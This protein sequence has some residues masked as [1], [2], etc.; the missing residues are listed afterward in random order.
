MNLK[1][2]GLGAL[3]VALVVAVASPPAGAAVA[4]PGPLDVTG[5]IAGAPFRIVVPAEWNG[6]LLV[7]AHGYVDKADHPGEVDER[8]TF[9]APG[10][11]TAATL[12]GQGWALAGT[13]YKDN[14]WAVQEALDDLVALTSYFK[15]NVGNPTRTLLVGG[16]MGSVPTLELAE[17][18]GGAFDG[19][20]AYCGLGGG[21]P[22]GADWLATLRLA[23]DVTFGLPASWGTVGDSRDDIDFESEVVPQLFSQVVNPLN[24][25]K[26]EFIRLVAGVPGSGIALPPS[27]NPGWLFSDMFFATEAAGE[28]ERRAGGP[29]MQNLT[30][31]YRL[32]DAENAYLAGLGMDADALL[33]AMNARRNISAPPSS[34]NYVEHCAEFSGRIKKPV[35]TLHTIVDE[36]VPVAHGAAYGA[37]VEAAG[38]DGL[39]TQAYTSGP[40]T[41]HCGFNAA[42]HVAA[43]NAL[44]QWIATGIR[45]TAAA[46]PPALGFL[47]GFVPPAWPQP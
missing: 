12:L 30:H 25:G 13:A 8:F 10:P 37:T 15:D 16:S 9:P 4:Q 43:V 44:D 27:L 19:Y 29:V 36:L 18:N 39:L 28:L 35:L 24:F 2:F 1:L 7:H 5:E 21:T 38:H 22:R 20:I 33:A 42:Q 17:R 41:G 3:L 34:R 32:S 31:R 47:P 6:K 26:F 14:G 46:L 45:P 23:Y 40:G 11:I